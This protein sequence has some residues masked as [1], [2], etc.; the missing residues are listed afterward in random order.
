MKCG[1]L[2][3][4][5][6]PLALSIAAIASLAASS[7][8]A[9]S[10]EKGDLSVNFDSSFSLGTSIRVEERDFSLI[11]NSN[12]PN[13][14]WTG[15]NAATNPIYTSR[16]V[17]DNANGAYST[18]GDLGD[19]NFDKGK[20]FS[21]VF[22]GT[23][24]LDIK[25]KNMGFFARG[26]YFYDFE[27][28]DGERDWTNPIT[29]KTQDPC[30]SDTASEELCSDIR[31]LDAFFYADFD[32]GN[33]P[34][35]L[36]IGDQVVSWGESTFIQH[37]INTTNPVDVTRSQAPGAELKEVFI[38]VGMVFAS[39]G[40]TDNLSLSMYYQYEWE[41]SRLPQAGSYFATNDFAGEG[42]Q[43]QNVQLGFTGNPDIDL[44]FLLTS[45]NGLGDALRAGA[46]A[47]QISA[48]YLAYPTKV[49]IRGYSDAAH[50]DADDQGQYGIKMS[51]Y[52]S[53]LNDTEFSLYHINYHSQR[54]LISGMT[55]DF[56]TAGIQRD[57]AYLAS[58]TIDRDNVT[59][60]QAFTES[61]FYYPE[62]LKLYGFSFNTNIGETAFAG[63][64]AYRV[65]EP[66]QIDDVELL[67]TAMPEQLANAGIRPDFAG[68]SQMGNIGRSVGPGETAQGYLLSDTVQAQFTATHV[69]GP[70]FGT[71]NF[72]LLG[73]VGFINIAD[74]PDPSVIR[75]NGPGTSRTPSLEPLR[76][77]DG[78]IISTREGLHIGLSDGP[79][80]NPFPTENAWG[81]RLL[82]V[83]DFNN[84]FSGVNLRTRATFAHDVNGTTPDPL[85]L[86]LEDRKSANISFEF[87][88]LSK[89]SAS[90]A[91]SSFW[92]GAGNSNAL[93]DRDFVSFNLKYSI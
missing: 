47:T 13:F 74:F 67:Y 43:A 65:D 12:H 32:L 3:F 64:I 25:Y 53:E 46:D 82:A 70:A 66:L 88:Y 16:D 1:P 51:Y 54:P 9:A 5:K 30:D 73:E 86:F 52:S 60:L 76:D 68:I 61:Q 36:R 20:A 57:L 90:V 28:K 55:S 24:E 84:V 62:D 8:F 91:Y 18:N 79:E 27:L 77:A 38:P 34:V 48:A 83:A 42:G 17:W 87:D 21:T 63:E 72:I 26:L 23:H 41:R 4:K 56:T 69:F 78:T 89:M 59:D 40:L 35:T 49:A 58:N 37:G 39:F 93:S 71:D 31:L 29:G 11:G 44:D 22:K 33:V 92:G 45:L 85:F 7:S 81:Y 19:L 10:W 6:S 14:D 50:V 2:T 75:L 80:T 15:Y